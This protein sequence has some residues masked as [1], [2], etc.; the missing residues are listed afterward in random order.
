MNW[1]LKALEDLVLAAAAFV[2]AIPAF[3]VIALCV[4]ATS[5]GPVFYRQE[6]MTWNGR[7]FQ[8]LK[9]RTMP[10]GTEKPGDLLWSDRGGSN[11]TK[12]GAFLRRYSLDELPQIVNVIKG[13]MSLVGPRPE[14]PEFVAQFRRE[15]PGYMQ[16]HLVKAG[17]TGWAQVNDL[18][19][20]T[21]VRRR[22]LYDLYYIEHWSIWF[23]LR[24]LVLTLMHVV[25]SQ[26]A[27]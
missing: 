11:A 21:D 12:F 5:R 23:D 7:R 18:R 27:R 2:L 8:I 13:E 17:M 16:K 6:R 19:G 22:V 10:P 3:L 1:L 9:F 20:D 4:K 15:I 24:I 26:H 14:R 25:R